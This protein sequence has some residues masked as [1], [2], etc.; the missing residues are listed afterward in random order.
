MKSISLTE[1]TEQAAGILDAVALGERVVVHRHGK[2]VAEIVPY[3][4]ETP[5]V[6]SWKQPFTPLEV[7]GKPLSQIIIENRGPLDEDLN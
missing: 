5:R 6:P 4:D 2:P 7:T 1:F 3:S